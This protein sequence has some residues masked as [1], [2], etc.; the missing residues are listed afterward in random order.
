MK[1]PD[2]RP[3]EHPG[4]VRR[5]REP[6]RGSHALPSEDAKPLATRAYLKASYEASDGTAKLAYRQLA[7]NALQM[8]T[9]SPL[10]PVTQLP[11]EDLEASFEQELREAREWYEA[12]RKDELTWIQQGKDP[13]QGFNRKY[14][15]EP[16]VTTHW[17]E[18][19]PAVVEANKTV[20]I[21]LAAV[22]LVGVVLLVKK[23][24]SWRRAA[25]LKALLQNSSQ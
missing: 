17:G 12:V 7:H 14:H 23:W 25:R 1:E 21:I 5:D 22:G 4:S 2:D 18:G 13:E 24:R 19:V 15:E 3:W 20:S 11:L 10:T 16:R 9:A 8:Q 6:H